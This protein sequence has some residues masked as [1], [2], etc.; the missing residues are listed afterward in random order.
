MVMDVNQ[1]ALY[2]SRSLIPFA[3]NSDL[4]PDYWKHLGVY[5]Y[6]REFLL[7]FATLPPTPM[8]IAES[9]EQ[10]RVLENGYRIKIIP[11]ESQSIGV[12]TPADLARVRQLLEDRNR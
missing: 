5:A 10:L 4:Q 6:R 2:F 12:D 3:R 1:Y 9:L 11:T 7:K 8:E